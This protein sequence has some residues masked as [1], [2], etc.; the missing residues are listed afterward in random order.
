M[1]DP[2]HELLVDIRK[3]IVLHNVSTIS[4]LS[5]VTHVS[6]PT[7][8]KIIDDM[9]E[10]GEVIEHGQHASNGGRPAK[11]YGYNPT[12]R[13]CL[14]LYIEASEIH[15]RL[16]DC[17]N[18]IAEEGVTLVKGTHLETLGTLVDAFD[19]HITNVDAI[20]VGVAAA[21]DTGR[22]VFAPEY[23]SLA[24]LDLKNWLM[25]RTGLPVVIENDMNAA[26]FGF[27]KR[28][29]TTTH[30][31]I[32]YLG[33]GK[34][35]PGAGILLD[36][37]VARGQSGFSGEVS[38]LPLYDD[39]SFYDRIKNK[40]YGPH[41]LKKEE[42]DALGRLVATFAATLNPHTF[43]F[44]D[45]DL[46]LDDLSHISRACERYL[47]S[48][49]IPRLQIG[50]WEEDYFFGLARLGIELMLETIPRGDV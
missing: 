38:F 5:K 8:K 26:V 46:V 37:H 7:V 34:N 47:P 30:Q 10:H 36:G 45:V 31:S 42:I 35:G 17:Q 27:S 32:V 1:K 12:F 23:P 21:V 41:L 43:I 39:A 49:H 9:I 40:P 20:S 15:Y 19:E 16:I 6:F 28:D 22:I 13:H 50:E 44:S 14:T 4:E 24:H 3:Q 25:D 33:L 2:Q 29:E 48:R 11:S 18:Q